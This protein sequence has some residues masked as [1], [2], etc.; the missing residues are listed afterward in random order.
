MRIVRGK[1]HNWKENVKRSHNKPWRPIG[2]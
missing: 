1:Q 2:L